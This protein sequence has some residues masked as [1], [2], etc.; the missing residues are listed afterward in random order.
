MIENET[1]KINVQR[2]ENALEEPK[3]KTVDILMDHSDENLKV[4]ESI[5]TKV[6]E[7]EKKI[8]ELFEKKLT[9]GVVQCGICE[10]KIDYTCEEQNLKPYIAFC[11]NKDCG[12]INHLRCLH[13]YFL[14]DEQIIVGKRNL[15]PRSGKCPNC[16]KICKWTTLVK[17]STRMK[18]AHGQ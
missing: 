15:I 13:R 18:I 3:G 16:D 6:I 17:F 2:S 5:Y 1:F 10:M 12:I 7:E 14:D 8:F 11:N 9:T 4:V